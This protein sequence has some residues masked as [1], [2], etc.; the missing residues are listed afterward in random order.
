MKGIYIWFSWPSL[1]SLSI[2]HPNG[3]IFNTLLGAI[4]NGLSDT[5]SAIFK[6]YEDLLDPKN[7]LVNYF[8]MIQFHQTQNVMKQ[9]YPGPGPGPK[10]YGLSL[11]LS[12][13]LKVKQTFVYDRVMA[14]LKPGDTIRLMLGFS[15]G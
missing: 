5:F 9:A 11:F 10:G 7:D 3:L 8:R 4:N 13:I 12:R 1:G 6:F 14:K 2:K 15:G